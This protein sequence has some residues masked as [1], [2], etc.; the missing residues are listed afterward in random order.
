[1]DANDRG[2]TLVELMIAMFVGLVVLAAVSAHFNIQKKHLANSELIAELHQNGRIAMDMMVRE[3]NMVGYNQRID[4]AAA[5]IPRCTNALIT[6]STPCVGITNAG[7]NTI[8]FSSDIN[9]NG[10]ITA[11][12]SNPNENIVYDVYSSG[13]IPALGRTSNGTKNPM[14]D[15]VESLTFQY[16]DDG[17]P[18]NITAV[19]ENIRRVKVTIRVRTAKEDPSYI[20]ATY[21]DHY[22][23]YTLSS[24]A[25]PRNLAFP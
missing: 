20:D 4:P 23:H 11:G 24:F 15:Y 2:F 17:D 13:S 14:V 21:G 10:D 7:A 18:G 25:F 12:E 22:R 3:I 9:G 8:S 1:M 5:P 6:A 16:Y 19:R